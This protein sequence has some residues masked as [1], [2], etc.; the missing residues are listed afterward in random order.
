M[1]TIRPAD[2]RGHSELGWLSSRHSFSFGDYYD[3]LQLGV[4]SLRVINEDVVQPGRGFET[5]G[6]RDME[7]ISYVLAGAL[8][9]KDTLGNGATI[10]P[11]EVQVMGAG[12]GIRHSE[13]NASDQ[14]P[15]H[16][17]QIWIRPAEAGLEPRYQQKTFP[18][19]QRRGRLRLVGSADGRDGSLLIRQ[20]VAVYAGLLGPG[21]Q[22]RLPVAPGRRVWVQVARG[23]VS[24]NGTR[25]QA[26]D[27]ASLKDE[28]ALLFAQDGGAEGGEAELLVFDLA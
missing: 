6:H 27:G 4:R 3:P 1:I 24:V 7:I 19:E 15:V 25:L 28:T 21:E 5:H 16:F 17:L 11:G 2:A 22:A 12:T 20:D 14:D 10:R 8:A 26:G 13:F 23:A 18:V 9:H